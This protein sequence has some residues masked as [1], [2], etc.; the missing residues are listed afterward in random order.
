LFLYELVIQNHILCTF[1]QYVAELELKKPQGADEVVE[2]EIQAE[3]AW[4]EG[5]LSFYNSGNDKTYNYKWCGKSCGSGTPINTLDT[6]CRTHDRCY[7]NFGIN[8]D[9]CD[10]D[11]YYCANATSDPGWWMVAEYGHI[12]AGGGA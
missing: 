3:A 7:A 4:Y 8:D 2:G 5:C 6:C 10:W 12:V 9:E 1:F 11:L